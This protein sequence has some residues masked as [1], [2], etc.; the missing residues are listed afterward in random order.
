MMNAFL[1]GFS[2]INN[3][4]GNCKYDKDGEYYFWTE[5]TYHEPLIEILESFLDKFNIDISQSTKIYNTQSVESMNSIN[6][7]LT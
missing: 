4:L 6:G 5:G 3:Y 1:C 2:T 7:K